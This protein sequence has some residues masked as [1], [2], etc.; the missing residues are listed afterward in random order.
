MTELFIKLLNMSIAASYLVLVVLL[1][2]LVFKKLPKSFMCVLWAFVAIRLL[3]P[4]SFESSFSLVPS[5]NTVPENIMELDVSKVDTG[6]DSVNDYINPM[7]EQM[8]TGNIPMEEMHDD[9]E[10]KDDTVYVDNA[11]TVHKN[12]DVK[13]VNILARVMNAFSYIWIAGIIIMALYAII[14]Y[15]RIY[16]RIREAIVYKDNIWLCDRVASPFILGIIRPRI[17]LPSDMKEKDMEYVVAHEQSHLKRYDH[18]W[19]P[20]G[21]M[22]LTVYWF[23]P[24][25]WL[26]YILLCRDI[27]LACDERVIKQMS[28][29]DK[30]EYTTALLDY[31]IS[32]RMITACPLAFG[33]SGVKSRIKSVLSYKKPAFWVI[34]AAVIVCAVVGI[35]F[36]TNPKSNKENDK[37]SNNLEI[38]IT[39]AIWKH[40]EAA[41]YDEYYY[42]IESHRILDIVEKGEETCVYAWV[43]YSEYG[44]YRGDIEEVFSEY[45]PTAIT[46]KNDKNGY[47][48][49]SLVEYWTAGDGDDYAFEI[50][51]KFP[52]NIHEKALD[53]QLYIEEQQLECYERADKHFKDEAWS[54]D[55]TIFTTEDGYELTVDEYEK[56]NWF[57]SERDIYGFSK[58]WIEDELRMNVDGR[59]DFI[60]TYFIR[61]GIE[62]TDGV[63]YTYFDYDVNKN[64][65]PHKAIAKIVMS[66]KSYDKMKEMVENSELPKNDVQAFKNALSKDELDIYGEVDSFDIYGEEYEASIEVSEEV[67]NKGPAARFI[68]TNDDTNE[69]YVYYYN[70]VLERTAILDT[71]D[72]LYDG[73]AYEKEYYEY[74]D[75]KGMNGNEII[76][77]CRI[78][79]VTLDR[80]STEQLAQAVIDYPMLEIH[81]ASSQSDGTD[82]LQNACDAYAE[83]LTRDDAKEVLM[84]KVLQYEYAAG[85]EYSD[86]LRLLKDIV[87]DE[88][89]FTLNDEEIS[90]LESDEVYYKDYTSEVAIVGYTD[91]TK[92]T[93]NSL[94][95]KFI[96]ISS[97][98]I[99]PVQKMDTIEQLTTFK[100]E[101][102]DIFEFEISHADSNMQFN[103]IAGKYDAAFFEKYTLLMVYVATPEMNNKRYVDKI[104]NNGKNFIIYVGS[105][106]EIGTG[107]AAMDGYLLMVEVP[108]DEVKDCVN[109]DAR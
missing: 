32:G 18:V 108:K 10:V 21:F 73:E 9:A 13:P 29:F 70:S 41:R 60:N 77:V 45:V 50:K 66:D 103:Q 3:I 8:N 83:L 31:S 75:T 14:S 74:P 54:D 87:L 106:Y 84:A 11:E 82:M 63:E 80:M 25:M 2:R 4:V 90:Y 16:K 33:E 24:I 97:S 100:M 101:Y 55:K 39:N 109:F 102:A 7:L 72:E 96:G 58:E 52:S 15:R 89:R 57:W 36:L 48:G 62:F 93:D 61:F 37:E 56:L 5:M 40:Y 71:N 51:E 23:N 104:Y 35:M 43:L 67:T 47:M 30:K 26:A 85:T 81:Y 19:K 69:V 99:Y 46:V 88:T 59:N 105:Q 53:S 38:F 64:C 76:A 12:A 20:L 49:Y 94:N 65:D 1:V 6:I 42:G 28:S 79:E 44:H 86:R 92:F 17:I 22:L 95:S 107:D 34:I 91:S 27:E 68:M 98:L 78:K